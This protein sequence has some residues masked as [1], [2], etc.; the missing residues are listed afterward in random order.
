MD[1]FFPFNGHKL[2][3][4]FRS[5]DSTDTKFLLEFFVF[6]MFSVPQIFSVASRV[7]TSRSL[8]V[9]DEEVVVVEYSVVVYTTFALFLHVMLK[10]VLTITIGYY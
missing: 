5:T 4:F 8:F 9:V 10:I 3:N 1:K 2:I 6:S 7:C